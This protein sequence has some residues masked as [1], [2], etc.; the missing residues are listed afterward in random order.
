MTLYTKRGTRYVP[1]TLSEQGAWGWQDLMAIAA[2]R[3]CL[4]RMTYIAGV[5]AD[6]LVDKWPELPP[7]LAG[8]DSHRTGPCLRARRRRQGNRRQPQSAGLGLRPKRVGKGASTVGW[9]ATASTAVRTD[10]R[11]T[12]LPHEVVGCGDGHRGQC[13]V[14]AG[15]I[16]R[17]CRA[18]Q[19]RVGFT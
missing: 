10:A 2:C 4:G 15:E 13:D 8:T 17:R 18:T 12:C 9:R 16:D 14:D 11:R 7:A 19:R 3:Y 5:C 6:W 1:T